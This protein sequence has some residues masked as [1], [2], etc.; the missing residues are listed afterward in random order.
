MMARR[1]FNIIL[2]LC[3][4][5]TIAV[6]PQLTLNAYALGME[7]DPTEINLK[8]V[9]AGETI[10]VSELS[11]EKMKLVIQNK[12]PIAYAY[13]INIIPVSET[14]AVIKSGYNDIPDCS[15]L[16]PE[17][18]EVLIPAN[19]TK[20]VELFLTVPDNDAYKG[21]NFQ[22]IVDIKNK[23]NSPEEVFVVAVQIKV[24][25]EVSPVE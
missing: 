18:K 23:K 14:G 22:A 19:G 12:S 5:S 25:I 10:A 21:K 4:I 3:I 8:D 20:E 9:P 7:V 13:E 1:V 17:E 2:V 24:N 11:R 6:S 15:W 16:K